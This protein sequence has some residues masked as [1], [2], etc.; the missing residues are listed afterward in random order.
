MHFQRLIKSALTISTNNVPNKKILLGQSY[1]FKPGNTMSPTRYS[2]CLCL[3]II[4]VFVS[5]QVKQNL[6][7]GF[8][9]NYTTNF[10]PRFSQISQFNNLVTIK[11]ECNPEK[12]YDTD[13]LEQTA[14]PTTGIMMAMSIFIWINAPLLII[15]PFIL[16]R[17]RTNCRK[18]I[19]MIVLSDLLM[20]TCALVFKYQQD[21][22]GNHVS[23]CFTLTLLFDGSV[24]WSQIW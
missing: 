6:R 2:F 22:F 12:F 14:F 5:H 23:Y 17:L 11:M 10:S 18:I 13:F 24:Q 20:N 9:V 21:K 8:A 19:G 3:S 16:P 7:S 4:E 1:C 15:G